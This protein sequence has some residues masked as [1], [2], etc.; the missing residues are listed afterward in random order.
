LTD[1]PATPQQLDIVLRQADHE[2][3]PIRREVGQIECCPF[4]GGRIYVT[5]KFVNAL[6][7]WLE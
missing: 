1:R 4:L 2:I 6:V 7:G 3:L 5:E